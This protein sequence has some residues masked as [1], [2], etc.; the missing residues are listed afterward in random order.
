[1]DREIA[2]VMGFAGMFWLE[3]PER[4]L[5]ERASLL[6]QNMAIGENDHIADIGAG[7]GY[8]VFKM[9]KQTPEG[10]IY[11]VDIQD[12]MLAVLE[13]K[14]KAGNH[15]NVSVIKGSIKSTNLPKNTLDKVLIV[16]VYHEMNYPVEMME[17]IYDA[18][19]EAGKLYL[20]EYYPGIIASNN[21]DDRVNGDVFKLSDLSILE[22][23]DQF[24]GIGTAYESPYEY[25]RAV[26]SVALQN[27]SVE[28]A[29]VYLYNWSIKQQNQIH[30]GDFLD[31]LGSAK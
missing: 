13:H 30:S 15:D 5:E 4:E 7:S 22:E 2:H 20:I 14:K 27:G 10:M 31:Y 26:Q 25:Q 11:A 8:H 1:M 16:D 24:E 28:K 3:R 23:L 19:K 9:A 6:L 17:S 21:P 12:E 29:W 18:L